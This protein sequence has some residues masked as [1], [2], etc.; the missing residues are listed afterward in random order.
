MTIG[1]DI[2]FAKE[3]SRFKNLHVRVSIKGCNS[4]EYQKLTN[5]TKESYELPYKALNNLIQN[6]VSCNACLSASF[7]TE[8]TIKDAKNKLYSIAP[9]ILKS[10]EIEHITLFPKVLNRLKSYNIKPN[11]VRQFGK[12]LNLNGV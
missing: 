5:A 3:L 8:Q 12:I 11:T 2:N 4:S 7:S 1:N 6:K 9:G 10:L